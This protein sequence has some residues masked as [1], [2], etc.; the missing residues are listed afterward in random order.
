MSGLM[1]GAWALMSGACVLMSE[2]L[3]VKSFGI[4]KFLVGKK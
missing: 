1:S 3:N 4:L 2:P